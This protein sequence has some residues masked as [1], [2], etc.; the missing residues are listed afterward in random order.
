MK[1]SEAILKG[2]EGTRKYAGH[3]FDHKNPIECCA[4]GAAAIA[5]FGEKESFESFQLHS[6]TKKLEKQFDLPKNIWQ[7]VIRLNDKTD[8]SRESIAAWL[9]EQGY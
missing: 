1:L 4:F 5:I 6:L 7:E 2:C 9:V 3:Y 8:A